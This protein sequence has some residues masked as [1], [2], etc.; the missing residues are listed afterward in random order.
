MYNIPNYHRNNTQK[1][2]L[3]VDLK[4]RI[5]EEERKRK[6]EEEKKLRRGD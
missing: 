4:R 3:F 5:A 6:E 1:K 2:D